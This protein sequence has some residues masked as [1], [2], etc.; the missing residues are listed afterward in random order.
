MRDRFVVCGSASKTYAMTGWRCG[1]LA[2]PRPVVDAASALQSHQTSNASS[3]AQ[4]A[5]LAALTGPQEC[6]GVMRAAYQERRNALM[7][8]LREEPRLASV[9]PRG[10]F[11]LFPNVG[12][13][14]S[15]RCPTSMAFADGLL[16]EEQVVVTPGEAFGV[17]GYIRLSYATSLGR[18]RE[19][20]TRLVRFAR[21]LI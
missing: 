1:W 3:I 20:A 8:W 19:G 2:G 6:V 10:A 12:A 4:H 5:V 9:T 16:R 7:G 14:L 21:G 18:L 15:P 13:F 17:P 11:Y